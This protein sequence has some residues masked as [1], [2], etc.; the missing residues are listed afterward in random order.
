M[1]VSTEKVVGLSLRVKLFDTFDR[2]LKDFDKKI[3]VS[4]KSSEVAIKLG[5]VESLTP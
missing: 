4:S 5:G 1:D 2:Q 3:R